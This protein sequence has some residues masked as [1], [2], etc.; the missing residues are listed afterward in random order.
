MHIYDLRCDNL[1]HSGFLFQFNDKACSYDQ[2]SFVLFLSTSLCNLL[3]V[4]ICLT[5]HGYHA[6]LR[7]LLLLLRAK[8]RGRRR[9]AGQERFQYD[10]F[11]SYSSRCT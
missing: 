6:T 9:G 2:V 1:K 11:I 7:Y 4:S 3:G 8:L 10:A 5:W